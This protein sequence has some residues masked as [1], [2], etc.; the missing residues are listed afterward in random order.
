MGN[1]LLKDVKVL[2]SNLW[3]VPTPS[4]AA[5]RSPNATYKTVGQPRYPQLQV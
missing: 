4:A 2:L 1:H 5:K 3:I